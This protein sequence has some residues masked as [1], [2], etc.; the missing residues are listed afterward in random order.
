MER[1][2][3]RSFLLG[4][5]KGTLPDRS[6]GASPAVGAGEGSDGIGAAVSVFKIGRLA[7]FPTGEIR[8]FEPGSIF[9]ESLPEGLRARSGERGGPC[10][11]ITANPTGELSVNLARTWNED[12]VFSIMI[13]GPARLDS[14]MEEN[15]ERR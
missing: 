6:S 13:G 8:R 10:Y 5:F 14:Y 4:G 12:T 15:D 3:R 1:M 11:E 9:V 7:D 2:N